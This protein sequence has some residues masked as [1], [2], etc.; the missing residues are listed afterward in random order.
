ME[1]REQNGGDERA[2]RVMRKP[3]AT[4]WRTLARKSLN[5]PKIIKIYFAWNFETWKHNGREGSAKRVMRKM[6]HGGTLWLS[7]A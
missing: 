6:L 2:E 4:W 7:I 5:P 3:N 1:T